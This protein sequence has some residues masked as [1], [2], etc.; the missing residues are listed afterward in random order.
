VLPA[1][2]RAPKQL[3]DDSEAE[4]VLSGGDNETTSLTSSLC[5]GKEDKV[6]I[7]EDPTDIMVDDSEVNISQIKQQSEKV[8]YSNHC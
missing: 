7:Y 8:C 1:R 3:R 6:I 2:P 5:E 4:Q